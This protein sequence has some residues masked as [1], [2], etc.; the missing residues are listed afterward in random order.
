[1]D[2][3]PFAIPKG[4][5]VSHVMSDQTH[6]GPAS[7]ADP[8]ANLAPLSKPTAASENP[9][10]PSLV[11]MQTS[12]LKITFEFTKQA[13]SPQTTIIKATH[14]NLSS[15]PY[16]DYLFQAAV[17][18]FMQLQLEPASS[19]ILPANGGGVI[20]QVV[21]AT[22]NMHG[23]KAMVMKLRVSFKANGQNNLEQAQVNNFPVGL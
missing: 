16:S 2:A 15:S 10:F 12:G 23:Q 1:L 3:D 11:A 18:K 6:N 4:S 5:V 7:N 21:K 17:P 8:F 22:N 19:N 13:N 14:T 20:T 9:A